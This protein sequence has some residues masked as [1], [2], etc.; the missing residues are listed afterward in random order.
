MND[1]GG[2]EMRAKQMKYKRDDQRF[3]GTDAKTEK[4]LCDG[5]F[6]E[7]LMI[8]LPFDEHRATTCTALV[9]A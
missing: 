3:E 4:L 8:A 5:R 9:E 6:D 7:G 2:W 1:R